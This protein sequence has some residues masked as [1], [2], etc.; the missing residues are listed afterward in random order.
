MIYGANG[1]TAGLILDQ[2]LQQGLTPI[3]AGRSGSIAELAAGHD[4]EYRIFDLNDGAEIQDNLRD[5]DILVNCAGPYKYTATPLLEACVA[6]STHYLD[7]T[8]EYTVFQEAERL[9]EEARNAGVIITPGVGFDIIPT[10][11]M[12]KYL[13]DTHPEGQAIKL[14]I[15]GEGAF[16]SK[17]TTATAIEGLTESDYILQDG[18]VVKVRRPYHVQNF[19]YEIDGE[20]KRRLAMTIG[21][22]DPFTARKSTGIENLQIYFCSPPSMIR[23]AGIAYRLRFLFNIPGVKWVLKKLAIKG[24]PGAEVRAGAKNYVLGEIYSDFKEKPL[25]RYQLTT[26]NGY[27]LTA[28][29]TVHAVKT[30]M[31]GVETSGYLTPSQLMGIDWLLQSEGIDLIALGPLE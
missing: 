17:G 27:D 26:M 29:G 30:L 25:A 13:V 1:F 10:D 8:G 15:Y 12:T 31:Q 22:P 18:K 20:K 6:T 11:G 24:D 23:G 5:I 2:A 19:T 4:L 9:E 21:L 3:L 28:V 14:A 16:P 7:I